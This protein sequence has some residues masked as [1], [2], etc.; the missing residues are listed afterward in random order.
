MNN[1][2]RSS[3]NRQ[4]QTSQ[5]LNYQITSAP[6]YL[7]WFGGGGIEAQILSIII[8]VTFDSYCY[9]FWMDKVYVT[10]YWLMIYWFS[11]LAAQ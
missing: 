10:G 4:V 1:N 11:L 7:I 5:K 6:N 8:N 2:K 3:C 9:R